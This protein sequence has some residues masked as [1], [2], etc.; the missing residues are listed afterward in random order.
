MRDR[1]G[2][3]R[4]FRGLS[5]VFAVVRLPNMR[6]G[7]DGEESADYSNPGALQPDRYR[8]RQPFA[9]AISGLLPV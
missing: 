1:G 2:F 8:R 6:D 3:A 5:L 9:A 4:D 7:N